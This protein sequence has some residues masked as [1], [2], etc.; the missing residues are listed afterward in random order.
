MLLAWLKETFVKKLDIFLQIYHL[1]Y[2]QRQPILFP[3]V[4]KCTYF[5]MFHKELRNTNKKIY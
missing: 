4:A 3:K 5:V 1:V 2:P